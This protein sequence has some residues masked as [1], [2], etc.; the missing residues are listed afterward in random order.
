MRKILWFKDR[1]QLLAMIFSLILCGMSLFRGI[2]I[3]LM[4]DEIGT[5]ASAPFLAGFDWSYAVSKTH[6]YG[7]GYYWIAFVLFKITDH[8]IFIYIVITFVNYILCCSVSLLIYTILVNK[9]EMRRNLN[10]SMIAAICCTFR[11]N[12]YGMANEYPVF[13]LTWIACWMLIKLYDSRKDYKRNTKWTIMISCL[14]IYSLS[15]HERMFGLWMAIVLVIVIFHLLYKISFLNEKYFSI[16]TILGFLIQRLVRSIVLKNIWLLQYGDKITNMSAISHKS[17]SFLKSYHT[18]R[19]MLDCMTTNFYKLVLSSYGIVFAVL[20]IVLSKMFFIRREM[21]KENNFIE[22]TSKEKDLRVILV[23]CVFGLTI[24][25]MMM[26]LATKG[27][28]SIYDG[29]TSGKPTAGYKHFFYMRYYYPF[30]SPIFAAG[31]GLVEK[32]VK[33]LKKSVIGVFVYCF[34]SFVYIC[35]AILPRLKD[36]NYLAIRTNY[37][38]IFTRWWNDTSYQAQWFNVIFSFF[39]LIIFCYFTFTLYRKSSQRLFSIM[40]L[41]VLCRQAS[42]V[43][44][45]NFGK[46]TCNAANQSY[47]FIKEMEDCTDVPEKVY[48]MN[49]LFTFQFV[50][51]RYSVIGEMPSEKEENVILFASEDISRLNQMQDFCYM[52]LDDNEFVYVK[53]DGLIHDVEK[54]YYLKPCV[55][56]E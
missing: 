26:G 22:Y 49:H 29:Y 25:I 51:S 18:I 15:V 2:D 46:Y 42:F 38:P 44:N 40:I 36:T 24:F 35:A 27:A 45:S 53:G 20:L 56:S 54:K 47:E 1:Y 5:I 33:L 9:F 52:Q 6:Y 41:V 28:G 16:I 34:I 3:S 39:I 30:I 55:G 12:S 4:A 32:N 14:I 7:F 13:I 37:S 11:H 31:Y 8:Y 23:V 43:W 17:F 50:L 48:C 19:T 21:C 10:T